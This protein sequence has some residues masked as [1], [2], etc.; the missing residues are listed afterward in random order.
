MHPSEAF[1]WTDETDLLDFVAATGWAR[2]FLTTPEGPRVAHAPLIVDR[3]TGT[4]RFHI[5]RR[6]AIHDSL[7][8]ATALA[9]LEGPHAYVSAIGTASRRGR[10]RRGI[11][12]RSS[13]RAGS[14]VSARPLSCHCSMR[15]QR[16]MKRRQARIGR[17][18]M[19]TRRES[20]PC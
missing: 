7:D 15:W 5:A 8:G 10:C 17:A 4:L 20:T 19:A 9:L 6:N 3:A 13:A 18:S 14:N 16:S 1:H 11:M 12:S 2:I